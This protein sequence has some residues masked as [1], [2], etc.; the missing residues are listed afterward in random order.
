MIGEANKAR[1]RRYAAMRPKHA[2]NARH[3]T[4][5]V[6]EH[7]T[8]ARQIRPGRARR[9]RPQG[10]A[11]EPGRGQMTDYSSA[12]REPNIAEMLVDPV[13]QAVMQ[14]DGISESALR[15]FI[16]EAR[17]IVLINRLNRMADAYARRD[18]HAA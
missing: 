16:A 3:V 5:F 9:M 7:F 8:G 13:V 14:R 15:S 4:C 12:G 6:Q 2:A 18:R 11:I 10:K 17:M 1:R